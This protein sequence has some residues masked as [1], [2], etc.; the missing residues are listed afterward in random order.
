MGEREVIMFAPGVYHANGTV[1]APRCSCGT[2]MVGDGGCNEGCCDDW[3]C[4]GC[5]KLIRTE[6]PD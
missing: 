6:A 1:H 5:G 3:K 2:Q 4:P